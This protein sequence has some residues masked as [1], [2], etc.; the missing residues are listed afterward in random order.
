MKRSLFSL[1]MVN[2]NLLQESPSCILESEM[3][4]TVVKITKLFLECIIIYS[5]TP[6][7]EILGHSSI[8]KYKSIPL[9]PLYFGH[10]MVMSHGVWNIGVH[11]TLNYVLYLNFTIASNSLV[12]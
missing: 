2:H 1:L 7:I 6:R 10:L 11:C 12:L 5:R 3:T 9:T 4:K 8:K